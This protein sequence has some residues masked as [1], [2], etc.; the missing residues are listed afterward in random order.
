MINDNIILDSL[1][2]KKVGVRFEVIGEI[3]TKQ[4]P[5]ATIIGNH[6]RVYTP[7]DT[8]MYENYVRSEYQRQVQDISFGDI[9]ILAFLTFYFKPSE[10]VSKIQ[11]KVGNDCTIACLNSKDCDNLVKI[12]LDSLNKIAYD[13]DRQI[14]SLVSSKEYAK[15]GIEK[16]EITLLRAKVVTFERAKKHAGYLKRLERYN[17]LKEKEKLT[18]VERMKLQ[19]LQEE[20]EKEVKLD[21][22]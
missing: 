19:E 22:E 10:E 3:K 7:Q 4:R 6:A 13:D 9:P 15:D 17:K 2:G 8:I 5:R 1:T 21:V 18:T 11:E 20:F 12:I 14:V 16:V